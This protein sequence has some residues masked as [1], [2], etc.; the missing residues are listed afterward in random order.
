MNSGIEMH[1]EGKLS[2]VD[3]HQYIGDRSLKF[4]LYLLQGKK[5]M[6]HIEEVEETK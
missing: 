3:G 4:L 6:L 5:V 2:V 1:L